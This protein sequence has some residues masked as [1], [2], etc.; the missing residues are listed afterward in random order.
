[1]QNGELDFKHIDPEFVREQIPRMYIVP[2][3]FWLWWK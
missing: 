2:D 3:N 1:L